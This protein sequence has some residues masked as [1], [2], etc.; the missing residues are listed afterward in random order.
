MTPG[1]TLM[2]APQ[3]AA[4]SGQITRVLALVNAFLFKDGYDA[5]GNSVQLLREYIN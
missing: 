2:A 4:M 1:Q 5:L 3:S